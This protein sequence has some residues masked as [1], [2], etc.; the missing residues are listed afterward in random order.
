MR[1]GLAIIALLIAGGVA[2]AQSAN[3]GMSALQSCFQDGRAADAICSKLSDDQGQQADCLRKAQAVQ[4]ECLVRVLSEEHDGPKAP[5]RSAAAARPAPAAVLPAPET[6]SEGSPSNVSAPVVSVGSIGAEGPADRSDAAPAPES[7]QARTF[8]ALA[9]A[10]SGPMR[11]DVSDE[12]VARPAE[13]PDWILSET[14]SPVD[15]SPLVAAVIRA[16]SAVS[17]GPNILVVRCRSG[18]T[19]FSLRTDAAWAAQRGNNVPV[20]YQINDRPIVRQQWTLSAD[21]KTA[22]YKD[23]PVELLRSIPEG[24]SLKVSVVDKGNV[25]RDATF[26]LAGLSA[27]RQRVA[28][29]CKW[30]PATARTS[31]KER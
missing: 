27:V 30:T 4:L 31:F 22:T 26:R 20:D 9:E 8:S 23:D 16:T 18:H 7:P 10:P 13:G 5:R 29:A 28:A 3:E 19:E 21:G 14:T 1:A 25:R 24:A 12:K 11:A 2:Q 6:P 17:D 15:Y